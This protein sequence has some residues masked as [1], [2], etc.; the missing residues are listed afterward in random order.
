MKSLDLLSEVEL[1]K[2]FNYPRQFNHILELGLTELQ[3][4]YLLGGKPLR[5]AMA[6]LA[7]R[8]PDRRLIPFA[9]RQDND[10]IACWQDGSNEEVFIIHDF[11][12][13]GWE[14][15]GRFTCFYDWLRRAIEDL[16][17]FDS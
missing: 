11:A 14:Q 1:P 2:G 10:D 5:A 4:W 13:S 9:R 3:P 6:G 7:Q 17:E 12:S 15:R 8:Y 16:I